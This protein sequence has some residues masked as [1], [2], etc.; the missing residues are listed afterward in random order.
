MCHVCR[1]WA[2]ISMTGPGCSQGHTVCQWF[3]E[4]IVLGTT[5]FP[6]ASPPFVFLC[7]ECSKHEMLGS[8]GLLYQG[9]KAWKDGL[10]LLPPCPTSQRH[11]FLQHQHNSAGPQGLPCRTCVPGASSTGIPPLPSDLYSGVSPPRGIEGGTSF[12]GHK[13]GPCL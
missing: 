12:L 10:R 6:L 4:P 8:C 13:P 5:G 1:Y 11:L 7:S 2:E 9:F 3:L